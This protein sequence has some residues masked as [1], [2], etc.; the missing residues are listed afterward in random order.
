MLLS[1]AALTPSVLVVLAGVAWLVYG[2]TAVRRRVV[3]N[4][5]DEAISGVLW[6][7]RGRLLVLRDAQIMQPGH[8]PVSMDGEVVID[9]AQVRFVQAV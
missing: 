3:V 5:G 6:A 7:R 2:R 1:I 8:E 4:L 9:R